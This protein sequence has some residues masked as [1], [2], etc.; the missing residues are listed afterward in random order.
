MHQ[1]QR[2][3]TR[4]FPKLYLHS[5]KRSGVCSVFLELCMMSAG[6]SSGEQL[7]AA[8]LDV[9]SLDFGG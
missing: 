7:S 3:I 5:L 6:K 1:R 8:A 4:L 9:L 2:F